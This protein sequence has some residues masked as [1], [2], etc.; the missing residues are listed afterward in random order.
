MCAK[1]EGITA[2]NRLWL[3]SLPKASGAVCTCH[4][5]L[6]SS[7]LQWGLSQLK[8]STLIFRRRHWDFAYKP[9]A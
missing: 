7:R 4:P 5:L 2:L 1:Q 9:T 6:S 8:G 3:L